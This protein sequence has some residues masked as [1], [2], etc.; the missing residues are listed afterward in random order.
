MKCKFVSA[1]SIVSK[2]SALVDNSGYFFFRQNLCGCHPGDYVLLSFLSFSDR[3][4]MGVTLV[5]M[6]YFP[7]FFRQDLYGCHPGNYVL[8]SFLFQTGSVRVSPW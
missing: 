3:I 7:F 8:L 6:S 5:I 1:E 2:N 4:C